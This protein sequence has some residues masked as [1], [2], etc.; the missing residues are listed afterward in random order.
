[1]SLPRSGSTLLEQMLG[2]HPD[3]EPIGELPYAPAILRSAME[4]ATRKG[5]V[6]VPQL[7]ANLTNEQAQAM[8]RDYL[9]RASLHRKTDR[10]YFVDKLPHNWSNILFIRR[11][12]PHARFIDIRRNPI[13]CCFSNFTQSFSSAHASSFALEDIGQCYVDYTRLMRHFD[14]V[15]PSMVHHVR[16]EQLIEHAEHEMRAVLAYLDLPWEPS[17]LEFYRLERVVRTPSSEQVRR[18]LNRDGVDAW[19]PY[20][21][22]LGPLNEVLAA[23][24]DQ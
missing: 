11:I 2:S 19:K 16:Y 13:D 17:I 15:A 1:V 9:R 5:E 7:I 4:M 22:W 14:Q 12:L 3:V 6:T 24:T 8:G 23:L 18:P 21:E 20:A 10:P